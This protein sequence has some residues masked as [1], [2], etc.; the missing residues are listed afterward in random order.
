MIIVGLLAY[1]RYI[2]PNLMM[3]RYEEINAEVELRVALFA[4]TH[5][6]DDYSQENI[7]KIVEKINASEP[8]IVV[9]V[10]D[11]FDNYNEDKDILDL[12]YLTEE[13]LKIEAPAYACEGNHDVGGGAEFIFEEFM[14]NA[15]F[16][17]L[18]NESLFL[19]EY[20]VNLVGFEE[21]F[22]SNP[23]GGLSELSE[24][25]YN[26][27]LIHQADFTENFPNEITGTVLAGHSH[28]GQ[29]YIP[30]ITDLILP[31]GTKNFRKGLYE[32]AASGGT[33]NV[34][35][36]SGLGTTSMELRF[37]NVPEVVVIDFGDY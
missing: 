32:G 15:G 29:V 23:T 7:E 16:T 13:L 31:E 11:F 24:T 1:A 33:M 28:G 35:V 14:E 37:L 8:D 25:E 12:D 36:T 2:E 10:G 17:V 3:V 30:Y 27:V 4:D 5:F 22:F 18:T 26:L 9:F 21:T 19:E 20:N 34:Y 6:G